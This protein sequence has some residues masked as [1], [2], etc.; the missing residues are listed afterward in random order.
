M[1]SDFTQIMLR[2]TYVLGICDTKNT[3]RPLDCLFQQ[4]IV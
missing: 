4:T 3:S 1:G 2:L